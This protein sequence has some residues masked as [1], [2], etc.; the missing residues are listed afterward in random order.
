M[1]YLL[2]L[3]PLAMAALTFAW[4]SDRS[5]PWLLPAGGLLHLVLSFTAVFGRDAD[6]PISGLGGWLLL[7]PLG[8]LVLCFL[9]VL[10]FVG[11]GTKMGLAP[12]HSWKP[13]AYGE[14]PAMVGALL[15]AGVTTCAFVA[16]LRVYHICSAG[17]EAAL[18]RDVMMAV[19]LFS[20]AVAAVF[21]A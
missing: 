19:G 16:I 8:K 2:I 3:L 1:I 13:D 4:P 18:A 14:A 17:A 7:D 12:M 5:R 6:G 9:S 15:A 10:L 11:Y 21:M 20:M